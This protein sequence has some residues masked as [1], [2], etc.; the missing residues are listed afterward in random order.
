LSLFP[1][2]G[3]IE[4]LLTMSV[5]TAPIVP[6]REEEILAAFY[7]HTIGGTRDQKISQLAEFLNLQEELISNIGDNLLGTN[8][9]FT[10]D[11]IEQIKEF[12]KESAPRIQ[13]KRCTGLEACQTNFARNI[14]PEQAF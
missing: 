3:A 7:R 2:V 14:F 11:L 4:Q 9:D 13:R 8:S 10:K 12:V 1:H 5:E 6:L